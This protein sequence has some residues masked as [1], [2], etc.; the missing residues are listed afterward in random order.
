MNQLSYLGGHHVV[1]IWIPFQGNAIWL[2]ITGISGKSEDW[3]EQIRNMGYGFN[4]PQMSLKCHC[5]SRNDMFSQVLEKTCFFFHHYLVVP[6]GVLEN[7]RQKRIAALVALVNWHDWRGQ[8]SPGPKNITA[9]RVRTAP[10]RWAM[11]FW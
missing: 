6:M 7:L 3:N 8:R 10:L 5:Q 2:V 4:Q 11:G 1:M 9:Q